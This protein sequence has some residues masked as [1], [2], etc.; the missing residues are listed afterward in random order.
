MFVMIE[1]TTARGP[2]RMA[3]VVAS[4]TN[5]GDID[6]VI[7]A[8]LREGTGRPCRQTNGRGGGCR[9]EYA[10]VHHRSPPITHAA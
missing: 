4:Q 9:Q 8:P 3:F 5:D 6:G 7:R 2:R 10:S 1:A